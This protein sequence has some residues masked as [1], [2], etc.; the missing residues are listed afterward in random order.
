[1]SGPDALVDPVLL[2]VDASAEPPTFTVLFPRPWPAQGHLVATLRFRST[3]TSP[4]E[5]R[6]AALRELAE[7][8]PEQV[9]M[10][11]EIAKPLEPAPE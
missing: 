9:A 6:E 10:V 11:R 4:A 3:A 7:L 2:D 8:T 5:L 1:M